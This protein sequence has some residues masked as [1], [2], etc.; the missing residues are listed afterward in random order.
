M[1]N[2]NEMANRV[3]YHHEIDKQFSVDFVS[4]LL[5]DVG[6]R[7][8]GYEGHKSVKVESFELDRTV[9]V[10]Y[11]WFASLSDGAYPR[12][13]GRGIVPVQPVSDYLPM[14]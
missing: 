10:V 9:Y 2:G 7:V 4:P 3:P 14:G 12:P 6:E 8:V 5:E 11:R 1:Y 13:K